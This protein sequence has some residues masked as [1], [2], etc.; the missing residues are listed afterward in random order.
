MKTPPS[1]RGRLPVAQKVSRKREQSS[2]DLRHVLALSR[3]AYKEQW[4]KLWNVRDDIGPFIA[5]KEGAIEGKGL[6]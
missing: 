3:D 4:L 6:N 5:A 1:K 2:F